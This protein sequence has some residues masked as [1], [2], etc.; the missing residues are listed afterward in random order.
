MAVWRDFVVDDGG[1]GTPVTVG[2]VGAGRWAR[3]T[4]GPMHSAPGPT[5]L[6]GVWAR[7]ADA[8][9]ELA[10][11]LGVPV[12]QRFDELLEA[13]EA[14]DF[15]VP[16]GVQAEMA[17]VAARAGK[18]LLL[19]K[20]LAKTLDQARAVADAAGEHGVATIVAL[21]RRYHPRTRDFL[22][23]AARLREEGPLAGGQAAYLH[24]GYLPGGFLAG[25]AATT[26]RGE[27]TGMLLDIGPHLLDVVQE[28]AGPV[29]AVRAEGDATRHLTLTTRHDGGWL[30]QSLLSGAV[31]VEHPVTR[32]EILSGQ[33]HL[34]WD[35]EGMAG[36]EPW[37][38]LRGEFAAAVRDGAPVTADARHAVRLQAVLHAAWV[39]ATE[40]GWVDVP[41][42]P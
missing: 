21:T 26:W 6:T 13:C 37:A 22:A 41:A 2:L 11:E 42:T 33:G 30:V 16:P 35:T 15:A 17:P 7:R 28:A 3:L 38:R 40:G 12:Y 39:S 20:P 31:A 19:E 8:A 1:R 23:A 5:R 34:R 10:N 29:E 9:E 14:V 18:A 24:G 25:T 36:D 27:P 4:H 32:A